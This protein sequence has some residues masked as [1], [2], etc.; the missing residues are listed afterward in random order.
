MI[1]QM[2]K[3]GSSSIY[4]SLITHPQIDQ[5]LLY[6]IHR[7]NPFNIHNVIKGRLS[8]GNNRYDQQD[9]I[10]FELYTSLIAKNTPSKYISLVREPINRNI[11]AFFQNY[12]FFTQENFNPN[13]TFP[14]EQLSN[15][16]L[17]Q[18]SHNVPLEWFDKEIKETLGIDVYE[19]NFPY[20]EGILTIKNNNF[21]LLIIK[22][23]IDDQSKE[24]AISEFL[25]I[26]DF[27]IQR[28]NVSGSK[29]YGEVYRKLIKEIKLPSEYIEKM[30]NSKY[31]THFYS[32]EEIKAMREKWS[33]N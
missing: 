12:H 16:F 10:G 28:T 13:Q 3:C 24:K 26:N 25:G 20:Q 21:E 30:C 33:R 22:C 14:L 15:L 5:N 29:N 11:S 23:E 2:G 9:L 32:V 8:Q 18:Y 27:K 19:Y 1:Y 31:M 7:I 6:H 4:H 17:T